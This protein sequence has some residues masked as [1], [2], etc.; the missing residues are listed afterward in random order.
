M[1][2]TLSKLERRT[3]A[4]D[5]FDHLFQLIVSLQLLPGARISEQEIAR[6]FSVSRQP[7]REAF[8]RLANLDLLLVRPQRATEVRKFSSKKIERSRFIRMAVECKVLQH[9]CRLASDAHFERLALNLHDQKKAILEQDTGKFHA[10]DYDFHRHLCDAGDCAPMFDT[11]S[12]NKA[13]VD[14]LC[15][16]G[17]AEPA[18]MDELCDDH[19]EIFE[20]LKRRDEAAVTAAIT[21][22]LSRLDGVIA[23]IQRTHADIFE[24]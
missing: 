18:V 12:E 22:H 6:Q 1:T 4:D 8:I 14:R 23:S 15:V 11:I 9:A 10:L 5:V 19:L 3:S 24:D 21:R 20:A 7:V 16:F 13:L 17:L 2:Q